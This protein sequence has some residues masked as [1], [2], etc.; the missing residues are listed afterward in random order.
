MPKQFSLKAGEPG[1]LMTKATE[2]RYRETPVDFLYSFS[3]L[4]MGWL[5]VGILPMLKVTFS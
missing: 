4:R 2:E 5:S 3:A 1:L